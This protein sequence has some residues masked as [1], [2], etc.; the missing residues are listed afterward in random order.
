MQ[1]KN[2]A[3]N[4]LRGAADLFF[5]DTLY[6]KINNNGL[7]LKEVEKFR[8]FPR[9]IANPRI[10]IERLSELAGAKGGISDYVS[11]N[12]FMSVERLARQGLVT[13]GKEGVIPTEK[14]IM[15]FSFF[16]D[17]AEVKSWLD[18]AI[19]KAQ[20]EG[21][22]MRRFTQNAEKV[23]AVIAGMIALYGEGLKDARREN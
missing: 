4:E 9:I 18:S 21:A 22:D 6:L 2:K 20:S 23:R 12:V 3:H 13:E 7:S 5:K 16:E 14:G 8:T 1:E 11:Y 19:K 15:L 17:K 10:S